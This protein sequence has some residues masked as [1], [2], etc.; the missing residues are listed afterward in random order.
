MVPRWTTTSPG[1]QVRHLAAVELE[2]A[3][4]RQ[5]QG[6]ID[7]L[8][9]VHE[10]GRA[11]GEFGDP[12][13]RALPRAD[14]IV[15]GDEPFAL[16][17]LA[18]LRVVGRHPIRRPDL[19]AGDVRPAHPAGSRSS[20]M[21]TALP[22]ASCPVTMRLTSMAMSVLLR[23]PFARVRINPGDRPCYSSG[24]AR[25]CTKFLQLCVTCSVAAGE[26][27]GRKGQGDRP[28][29]R[30]PASGLPGY[31]PDK[32][33]NREIQADAPAKFPGSLT[34]VPGSVGIGN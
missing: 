28:D 3:L 21:I 15:A 8:G 32:G 7:G 6:V 27:L 11:G 5:Q 26:F 31:V 19:T 24:T 23:C 1:P 13:N 25:P 16:S 18:R 34:E 29:P 20:V 33:L 30:F 10:F 4:A 12:N 22:F 17:G 9:T 14:I 2:V